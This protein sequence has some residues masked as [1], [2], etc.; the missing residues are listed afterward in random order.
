MNL[1]CLAFNRR[2]IRVPDGFR[3]RRKIS[4]GNMTQ[5]QK[6]P[7]GSWKSP[8]TSDVIVAGTIGLGEIALDG[9][10]TYWIESRP[11]ER[12]RSVIVRR[13]PDGSVADVT[14]PGLNARTTV[15]E[16]GGGAY[17]V[18]AGVV[19]FSNFSDQRLYRQAPGQEPQSLTSTDKMRYADSVIDHRRN[20]IYCVR[21]D[22]TGGGRDAINTLV[23]V[24]LEGDTG[25]EI[26]VS[27]NDFYSSPR[28]SPNGSR[29][30]WLTWN[31][32]N[33]PWDG[34][35]LWIGE[36]DTEGQ[37]VGSRLAA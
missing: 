13:T 3:N 33:L 1:R 22:H 7:Y 31:H 28:L 26:I 34:T 30:A 37:I 25:G 16:Y 29:L 5:K 4:P 35:E 8:I 9:K 6:S 32:P 12:G 14:P 24:N 15:H 21:E 17:L 2:R 10:D 23:R 36:L 11:A 18:D 19:Y 27:G 20:L